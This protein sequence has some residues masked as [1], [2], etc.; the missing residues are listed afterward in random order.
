MTGSGNAYVTGETSSTDFPTRLDSIYPHSPYTVNQGNVFIVKLSPGEPDRIPPSILMIHPLENQV[1]VDVTTAPLTIR[2][3]ITDNDTGV[4]WNPA[5][6]QYSIILKHDNFLLTPSYDKATGILTY[7]DS[8]GFFQ[9]GQCYTGYVEARDMMKN[10]AVRW[11]YFNTA[12]D[13]DPINSNNEPVYLCPHPDWSAPPQPIQLMRMMAAAA[14]QTSGGTNC[15]PDADGDGIPDATETGSTH[16]TSTKGT[17]F[18]KPTLKAVD[19]SLGYWADFKTKH[20]AAVSVPFAKLNIELVI[21]GDPTNIYCSGS[22][23][24]RNWEYDPY[25]DPTPPPISFVEVI[26]DVSPAPPYP[27][28]TN[29]PQPP[30]QVHTN[31]SPTARTWYWGLLGLTPYEAVLGTNKDKFGYFKTYIYDAPLKNYLAERQ[32]SSLVKATPKLAQITTDNAFLSP[33]NKSN[34]TTVEMYS[35]GGYSYDTAGTITATAT[36]TPTS[37]SFDKVL[38]RVIAHEIVHTLLNASVGDHCKDINCLMYGAIPN[39]DMKDIG[40]STCTVHAPGKIYDIRPRVKNALNP[41]YV[42]A[43]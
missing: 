38:Q 39:W 6:P 32:Y 43:Q 34:D 13:T 12:S 2:I 16:T 14:T 28:Q 37:Y 10:V 36:K 17:I 22:L 1:G 21:V 7:V 4:Y 19:G 25:L 42:P 20:L 3:R 5:D 33:L 18:V 23:C 30:I 41:T 29:P 27:V 11:F 26:Y 31:F 24:L 35:T 15:L 9:P 40:P 8:S